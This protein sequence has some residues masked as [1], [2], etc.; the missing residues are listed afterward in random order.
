[1]KCNDCGKDIK[2][3]DAVGIVH[4]ETVCLVCYDFYNSCI[5]LATM[6]ANPDCTCLEL[7]QN[8]A[9]CPTCQLINYEE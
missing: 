6:L 1:M 2:V 5:G 9:D 7:N 3:G 4:D 8:L